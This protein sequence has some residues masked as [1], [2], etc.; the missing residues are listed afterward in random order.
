MTKIQPFYSLLDKVDAEQLIAQLSPLL[1]ETRKERIDPVLNNRLQSIHVAVENPGNIHN[2]MAIART[3][4]S[5]GTMHL[6]LIGKAL[7]GR[8]SQT[9]QGATRWVEVYHHPDLYS[10]LLYA[11][12]QNLSLCGADPQGSSSLQEIAVDRP[13]CLLFGNEAEGLSREAF[14]A[15]AATFRIS[16]HGF[17]ESFNLSVAAGISLYEV[18]KRKREWLGQAGDLNSA[19]KLREKAW[20][21]YRTVGPQKAEAFIKHLSRVEK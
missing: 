18:T 11:K 3:C 2:A 5:L 15:C 21:Y 10:F 8:G 16:M 6:H 9:T 4:E 19:Q 12:E 20:F 14:E 1:T 7:K 17:S 13:L